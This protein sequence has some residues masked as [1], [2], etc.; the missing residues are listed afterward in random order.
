MF[1][2]FSFVLLVVIFF[3]SGNLSITNARNAREGYSFGLCVMK[4]RDEA[5]RWDGEEGSYIEEGEVKGTTAGR[6]WKINL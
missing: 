4:Y 3:C 1:L 6:A 2:R 5:T